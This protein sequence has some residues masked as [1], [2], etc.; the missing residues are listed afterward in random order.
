MRWWAWLIVAV[1]VISGVFWLY[2]YITRNRD[3]ESQLAK[4]REAKAEKLK[5]TDAEVSAE[6]KQIIIDVGTP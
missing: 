6:E 2:V 4:A 5:Q 1:L 3:K